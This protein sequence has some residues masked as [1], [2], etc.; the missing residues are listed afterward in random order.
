MASGVDSRVV[1]VAITLTLGNLAICIHRSSRVWLFQQSQC[2]QHFLAVDTSRIVDSQVPEAECKIKE[3]QSPLSMIEG[4][5]MFLQMLPGK[6]SLAETEF[7]SILPDLLIIALLVLPTYQKLLPII[8]LRRFLFINLSFLGCGVF[9][10]TFFCGFLSILH[11]KRADILSQTACTSH[12]LMQQYF[13]RSSA[14]FL[15]AVI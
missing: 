5:D 15:V 13:S 3:V 10:S 4:A 6:I 12:G 2:L 1:L 8:G 11:D 14:T 9:L 7:M